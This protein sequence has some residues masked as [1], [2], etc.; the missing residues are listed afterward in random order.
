MKICIFT[1]KFS[2]S[3]YIKRG[4]KEYTKR[5]SRYCQLTQVEYNSMEQ[6]QALVL[7]KYFII[8]ISSNFQTITSETFAHNLDQLGINGQS[9][10]A[11]C[12]LEGKD[13]YSMKENSNN[14]ALSKM[15]LSQDISLLMLYEQLYR[16][17]RITLGEPYHK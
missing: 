9:K 11:L 5:L 4:I 7:E 3:A 8:S 1:P 17:Y 15:S 16:S 14:F 12:L 10:I 6:L 13:S 2:Y